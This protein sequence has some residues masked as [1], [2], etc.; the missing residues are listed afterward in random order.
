MRMR[1]I[2]TAVLF[3]LLVLFLSAAAAETAN[4]IYITDVDRDAGNVTVSYGISGDAVL[5]LE[6]LE[7]DGTDLTSVKTLRQPVSAE[8]YPDYG[9]Y[10]FSLKLP[11]YFQLEA[12]LEGL[13]AGQSAEPCVSVANLKD[14]RQTLERTVDDWPGEQVLNFDSDKTTNYAVLQDGVRVIRED[15]GITISVSDD[16][17]GNFAVTGAE[18]R[19]DGLGI[20]GGQKLILVQGS[21]DDLT[22][23]CVETE[24]VS[25]SSGML[26][27]NARTGKAEQYFKLISFSKRGEMRI[28]IDIDQKIS[29]PMSQS[30]EATIKLSG[31]LDFSVLLKGYLDL[32]HLNDTFFSAA[33]EISM[34]D[35]SLESHGDYQYSFTLADIDI[36]GVS[37]P[38]LGGVACMI[39]LPIV[40]LNVGV[41]CSFSAG[42]D[43]SVEASPRLPKGVAANFCEPSFEF[44][45][46]DV[47]GEIDVG[48]QGTIGLEALRG[49]ALDISVGATHYICLAGQLNGGETSGGTAKTDNWHA[50]VKEEN[51]ITVPG[52]LNGT[53]GYMYTWNGLFKIGPFERSGQLEVVKK[54]RYATP[55]YHSFIFGDGGYNKECPHYGVRA[56][57]TV[58][59][60]DGQPLSGATVTCKPVEDHFG[61]KASAVTDAN[62]KA[63]L[64][65]PRGGTEA[66]DMKGFEI[67]AAWVH[68]KYGTLTGLNTVAVGTAPVSV[69]VTINT[70]ETTMRFLDYTSGYEAENMPEEEKVGP[71][72]T[73]YKLPDNIPE[74]YTMRFV[75]WSRD[76]QKRDTATVFPGY[77]VLVDKTRDVN[78]FYAVWE[79][80]RYTISYDANGGTGAPPEQ[81]KYMTE[82]CSLSL[83]RPEREGYVFLGWSADPEADTPEYFP[84]QVYDT[85]EDLKL[86]AVWQYLPVLTYKV[87]Y[88]ANAD[89]AV[90]VP[91]PQFA[92]PGADIRLRTEEPV[93]EGPYTFLGWNTDPEP[94]DGMPT[95]L[96]GQEYTVTGDVTLYAIWQ[97]LPVT[98]CKVTYDANADDAASVPAPQYAVPGSVICL[99]GEEPVREGPYLFLGWNPDPEPD[100]GMPTLLAGQEYT[101]TDDVTLYAIWQT[102]PVTAGKI[103][104]DAN[105]GDPDSVPVLQYA[106]PGSTVRLRA[107]EP[108]WD[109]LHTFLGWNTDP[110]PDDGMPTLFPGQEY[111]FTGDVTLYAIWQTAP[112]V[113]CRI[114][115]DANDDDGT[116]AAPLTQY[117]FIG[118][119]IT[120]SKEG[121][122]WDDLH[123]FLGWNTD[124]DPDDGMPTLLPGQEY[125]VTGDVTLYAIWQLRPALVYRVT[126]DPAPGTGGPATQYQSEWRTLTLSDVLPVYEGHK[127]AG[128]RSSAD[129]GLWQPGGCYMMRVSTDMTAEWEADY[130]ILEG[131]GGNYCLGSE[132]GLRLKANGPVALF[133]H[134]LID[135]VPVSASGNYEVSS[136]S[137]VCD[138]LA[139]YLEKLKA[140]EHT[141]RFIYKDGKTEEGHFTVRPA[142]P[143]TGDP[144]VPILS[145]ILAVAVGVA[146]LRR[147]RACGRAQAQG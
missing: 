6:V 95:L 61:P 129:G 14:V 66:K 115:Y 19:L 104:Y 84:G 100:D 97:A 1:K 30:A 101:V 75:G 107:G 54:W 93:R 132:A 126:Y 141:F 83:I 68:E 62:G 10:T 46:D 122:T 37:I 49:D 43:F 36:P 9:E 118:S 102:V 131:N 63:T 146:V 33:F 82:R 86:Y 4:V 119:E 67:D 74:K 80:V 65:L 38:G 89:D 50:C 35:V 85:D 52:C 144:G 135:G 45:V 55:W 76:Y 21:G 12:R 142:L 69:T 53:L 103:L 147:K 56:D 20:A 124:P 140:G 139:R 39:K 134:L 145:G 98:A 11:E 116:A 111:A 91:A 108:V 18:S 130:H 109:E 78:P 17:S 64:Y 92:A 137:T 110:E 48:F 41:D 117:A 106:N 57:V 81:Y 73:K 24:D 113:I 60:S 114:V 96:P 13:P 32:F 123:T 90:S 127:L 22:I 34:A 59:N 79:R 128:W 44:K 27:V 112:A 105:G 25:S 26:E 5:V 7:D 47:T 136:G 42:F 121:A 28:P 138:L 70:R 23:Q 77:T 143:P 29:D 16:G 72:Q 125:T 94:D 99:R 51:G 8:S 71:K 58:V 31:T 15:D 88:D 2:F 3:A 87:T 133:D 120:L 40:A